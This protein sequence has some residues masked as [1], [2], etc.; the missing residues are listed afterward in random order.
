MANEFNPLDPL[1]IAEKARQQ[2]NSMARQANLPEMPEPPKVQ[3]I[4]DPLGIFS[5]TN[6]IIQERGY[7][8]DRGL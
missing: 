7:S 4:I 1:G 6:S 8:R 3:M 5:R 2:V